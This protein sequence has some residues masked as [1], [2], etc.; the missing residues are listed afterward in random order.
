MK[1]SAAA[2]SVKMSLED[3]MD[4][5]RTY[6]SDGHRQSRVEG[7]EIQ[8]SRI[9]ESTTAIG[10]PHRIA[11]GPLNVTISGFPT[12]SSFRRRFVRLPSGARSSFSI[13]ITPSKS[14]RARKIKPKMYHHEP[15]FKSDG[16]KKADGKNLIQTAAPASLSRLTGT[17]LGLPPEGHRHSPISCYLLIFSSLHPATQNTSHSCTQ[18]RESFCWGFLT[19]DFLFCINRIKKLRSITVKRETLL[20]SMKKNSSLVPLEIQQMCAAVCFISF[21]T[22]PGNLWLIPLGTSPL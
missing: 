3:F 11:E 7:D 22:R 15:T 17:C 18:R 1:F 20:N 2:A 21:L 19:M 6:A 4:G 8:S 14:P 13:T 5:R 10:S 9:N 12:S 16:L